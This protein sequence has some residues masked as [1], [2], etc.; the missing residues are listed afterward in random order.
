MTFE[1]SYLELYYEMNRCLWDYVIEGSDRGCDPIERQLHILAKHL[2]TKFNGEDTTIHRVVNYAL[3]EYHPD[4]LALSNY[5]NNIENYMIDGDLDIEKMSTDHLLLMALRD[6]FSVKNG[7]S[8]YAT[9]VLSLENI[10]L[11]RL[12]HQLNHRLNIQI[13][14]AKTLIKKYNL[15]LDH[16]NSGLRSINC[17]CELNHIKLIDQLMRLFP[18]AK[19]NLSVMR[20]ESPRMGYAVEAELS[21]IWIN[22]H[23]VDTLFDMSVFFHQIGHGLA[24]ALDESSGIQRIYSNFY[25]ELTGVLI[26]RL[27]EKMLS[28][29]A[30][31][32]LKEIRCLQ[33]TRFGIE[34]LYELD[35]WF[36][37]T[38]PDDL[39]RAHYQKIMSGINDDPNYF[40]KR[41]KTTQPLYMYNYV[42]ADLTAENIISDG[43]DNLEDLAVYLKNRVFSNGQSQHW[44][45][46]LMNY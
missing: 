19:N 17:S 3:V 16:W 37:D 6:R 26:E 20:N 15:S 4:V 5:L 9:M 2:K 24:H 23:R 38:S 40:I 21:E 36:S 28:E 11:D 12:R 39:F 18:E 13:N 42:L 14:E 45:N 22:V 32:C 41:L 33:Y 35:L 31:I 8:S 27:M 25:E 1:L 44:I 43:P 7:F 30:Q 29:E 46:Y 34:A 10:E